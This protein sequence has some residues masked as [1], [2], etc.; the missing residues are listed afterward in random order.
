MDIMTDYAYFILFYYS[1][2]ACIILELFH[3]AISCLIFQKMLAYLAAPKGN[4]F[5]QFCLNYLAS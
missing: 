2:N 5:K 3:N 4:S 1:F